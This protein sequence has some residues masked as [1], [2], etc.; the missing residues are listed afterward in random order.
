M[1]HLF[2]AFKIQS[3]Y[4]LSKLT[5]QVNEVRKIFVLVYLTFT[6]NFKVFVANRMK[7]SLVAWLYL[8][9]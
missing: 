6:R 7:Y 5:Q 4:K 3:I 9:Y 1:L 2:T 8:M